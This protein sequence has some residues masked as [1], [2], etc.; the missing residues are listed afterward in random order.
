MD[1]LLL[2]LA[3]RGIAFGFSAA[4][5]PGPL[6]GFLI[7][8][9]LRYGWRRTLFIVV[10]PLI[11]DIPIILAVLLALETVAAVVPNIVDVIRIIGGL[12]VFYLAWGAL[13]DL[14]QKSTFA[15]AAAD[16]PRA[17]QTRAGTFSRALVLN[18]VSPGP[19]IFWTTINGP[20]LKQ[21]L[22]E[23]LLHGV[24]FM[25]AFYG[26]FLS[27]LIALAIL[28]D[29]LGTLDERLGTGILV[30]SV[31]VLVL[32]GAWLLY[33]GISAFVQI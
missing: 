6:Q 26:T 1:S 30:A 24:V 12:F 13:Q 28:I 21:G 23:S 3:G 32:M 29:W 27:G 18:A 5:V 19:Y 14:R 25:L 15:A 2:F 8:T 9:S 11:V 33:D 7:N 17:E 22:D 10:S 16:A 20:L 4:S 31:I